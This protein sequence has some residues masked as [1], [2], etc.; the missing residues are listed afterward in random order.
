MHYLQMGLLIF[1]ICPHINQ[2]YKTKANTGPQKL[3]NL[4][5]TGVWYKYTQKLITKELLHI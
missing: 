1:D 4:P 5:V 2:R 3:D